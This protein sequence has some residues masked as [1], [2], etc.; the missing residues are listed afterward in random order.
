VTAPEVALFDGE[1]VNVGFA[2]AVLPPPSP[3]KAAVALTPI[4]S[5]DAEAIAISFFNA[6]PFGR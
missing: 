2:V 5:S 3:A 4:N 1:L 6:L